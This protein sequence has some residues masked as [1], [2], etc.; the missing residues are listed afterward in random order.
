MTEDLKKMILKAGEVLQANGATEVFF[1]GS[2]T[3]ALRSE[4]TPLD[5]AVSG[6]PPEKFYEAMGGMLSVVKR[7]CN[8]V[9]LDEPT[10]YVEY[11]KSHGKIQ[12]DLF[13]KIKNELY[14]LRAFIN[15]FTPFID[16][17]RLHEPSD[18]G[19]MALAGVIQL[20]YNGLDKIFRRIVAEYDQG[21]NTR[22][23]S[24][25][26]ALEQMA[27]ATP[28]RAA[29]LSKIVM[30]QLRAYLSFRQTFCNAHSYE[31]AWLKIRDLVY[32]IEEVFLL[33]EA[34]LV[35]FIESR[36]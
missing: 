14:Q 35:Y 17:S 16:R 25:I 7:R 3:S 28:G 33:V 1:F 24:D 32:E 23:I 5:L 13:S 10:P 27:M 34:E 22:P 18:A 4:R 21:F 6:L 30:E 12:P 2:I 15:N 29:V 26:D 9:D 31:I 19:I 11:L 20:F 36:H 8:L